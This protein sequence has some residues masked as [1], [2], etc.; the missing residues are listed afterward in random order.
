MQA[1][2]TS[3]CQGI[4]VENGP[5]EVPPILVIVS[6]MPWQDWDKAVLLYLTVFN[7]FS[8][9]PQQQNTSHLQ[10]PSRAA[11]SP[12]R[13]THNRAKMQVNQLWGCRGSA[14]SAALIRRGQISQSVCADYRHF[15]MQAD[16]SWCWDF[17]LSSLSS[18]LSSCRNK[19]REHTAFLL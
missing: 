15:S 12:Q 16:D 13:T 3:E 4:T 14:S 10:P 8:I 19:Q 17:P 2:L 18:L 9:Y 6:S 1:D 7:H 11:M 5:Y